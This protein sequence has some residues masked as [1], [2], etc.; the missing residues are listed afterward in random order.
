MYSVAAKL[1]ATGKNIVNDRRR[2]FSVI[3]IARAGSSGACGN[4][5]AKDLRQRG[6]NGELDVYMNIKDTRFRSA[7]APGDSLPS[8]VNPIGWRITLSAESPLAIEDA[9]GRC[10]YAD[11][12]TT[13]SFISHRQAE[14]WRESRVGSSASRPPR[15][16]TPSGGLYYFA[17][18]RTIS[19]LKRYFNCIELSCFGYPEGSLAISALENV[20][21]R[22]EKLFA[23]LIGEVSPIDAAAKTPGPG[24]KSNCMAKGGGAIAVWAR[25]VER[26]SIM[27]FPPKPKRY[28]PTAR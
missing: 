15:R 11:F 7:T 28:R 14:S 17:A 10:S 20:K 13:D 23:D 9:R 5:A 25:S 26:I 12:A 3:L 22:K 21:C 19:I 18:S 27:A 8:P 4:H 6:Y 24:K 16:R 2:S 1:I